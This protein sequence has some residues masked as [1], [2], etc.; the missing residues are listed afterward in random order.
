MNVSVA[1]TVDSTDNSQLTIVATLVPNNR[2]ATAGDS[3]SS[4]GDDGD[5]AMLLIPRFTN[6]RAGSALGSE[7]VRM[8]TSVGAGYGNGRRHF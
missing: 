6:G 1:A 5:V 7:S 3:S 2:T 8:L 4:I